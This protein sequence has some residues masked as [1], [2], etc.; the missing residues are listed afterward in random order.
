M[1]QNAPEV[2]LPGPGRCSRFPFFNC[3]QERKIL[4]TPNFPSFSAEREERFCWGS[5]GGIRRRA[6]AVQMWECGGAMMER[7][8]LRRCVC[9][10]SAER[11]RRSALALAN[12]TL[13]CHPSACGAKPLLP[14]SHPACST[15]FA[16]LFDAEIWIN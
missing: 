6:D 7:R 2:R 10:T 15:G 16:V 11:L 9:S 5:I 4:K 3:C 1:V 12:G 8:C 13:T 14:V